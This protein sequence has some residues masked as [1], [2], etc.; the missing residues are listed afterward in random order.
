MKLLGNHILVQRVKRTKSLTDGG[1]H[2]PP[3]MLDDYNTGGC[4][5]YY[6]LQVGP[7]RRNRKGI[8]QPLECSPGD[9]VICQ[10]FT[11]GAAELNDGR[12]VITDDM[13]IAVIPG[14]SE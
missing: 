7:G 3:S 8:L 9:R 1:I 6:V 2:L 13:M 5:E 4:K 12:M 11:T 10:S 14:R